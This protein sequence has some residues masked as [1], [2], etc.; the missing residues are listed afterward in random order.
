M[1]LA[2]ILHFKET[3][4]LH[5]PQNNSLLKPISVS[6][7]LYLC[8]RLGVFGETKPLLVDMAHNY[9]VCSILCSPVL[10]LFWTWPMQSSFSTWSSGLLPYTFSRLSSENVFWYEVLVA[11]STD[12][13]LVASSYTDHGLQLH[14]MRRVPSAIAPAL[15]EKLMVIFPC[16]VFS[17]CLVFIFPFLAAS[18]LWSSLTSLRALCMLS[19]T[20]AHAP[21]Q[22]PSQRFLSVYP[23]EVAL[24]DWR[25]MHCWHMEHYCFCICQLPWCP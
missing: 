25:S 18:A 16:K 20:S 8:D 17:C 24:D 4:S 2:I 19:S 12:W 21:I 15:P 6:H 3:S 22:Q 11:G 1:W 10:N 13:V 5:A 23:I 7:G 14:R 9:L